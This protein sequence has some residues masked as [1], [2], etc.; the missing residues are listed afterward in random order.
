MISST[1]TDSRYVPLTQQ[2][3]CCVPTC[4]QMVMLRHNI[5]L[6]PAEQ[7]GYEMGLVVPE[8]AKKYFWNARTGER[9]P[10]GYGTQVSKP[11]YGPNAVFKRLNIP[12]TMSWSLIDIFST[13]ESFN[14]YLVQAEKSDK[15]ILVCYDWPTLFNHTEKTHWGH[16]CVLDKVYGERNIVRI[17]DPEFN[18]PTWR[19]VAIDRL[20][21]A[22]V[23]HGSSKSGGFWEIEYN[24]LHE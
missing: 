17:I 6:I 16:V 12:L 9:P 18:A 20:Y 11:E 2:K 7:L 19:E 5:P 22:M 23:F 3:W 4:I 24:V 13:I 10:A 15:D 21:D 8:E 14:D 1:P